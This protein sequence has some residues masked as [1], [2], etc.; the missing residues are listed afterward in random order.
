MTVSQKCQFPF[1]FFLLNLNL[2]SASDS[3]PE[4]EIIK[5]NTTGSLK[6]SVDVRLKEKVDETEL[7]KLAHEIKDKNPEN[8]QRTFILYYLPGMIVD[9]GAWASSHFNPEL[10]VKI[11]GVP[12]DSNA[13]SAKMVNEGETQI[14]KWEFPGIGGRVVVI[15]KSGSKY[16]LRKTYS[17]GSSNEEAV[18]PTK[19]GEDVKIVPV[20][21]NDFGEYWL[22]DKEKVLNMMDAEGLIAKGMPK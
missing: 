2:V 17:D 14:G 18:L 9:A 20:E 15:V 8:F 11:L 12:K 13:Y 19:V 7:S 5:D 4:Y 10:E 6:R 22:L 3:L 16:L 21:K 1:L